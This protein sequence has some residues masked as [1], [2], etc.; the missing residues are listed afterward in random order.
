MA[1]TKAFRNAIATEDVRDIRIMMKDSLIV[2]PTFAEFGERESLARN[3]GQLYDPHDGR[4]FELDKSAWDDD[5]MNKLMVQVV[6]NF[7][8]ERIN[9]LKD[10]VTHLYPVAARSQKTVPSSGYTRQEASGSSTQ[11]TSRLNY[12][13]QRWQNKRN[14]RII[15][16]R[17]TRIV[18]GAAIGGLVGG[19]AA[20]VAGTSFVIGAIVGAVVASRI[21]AV[22]TNGR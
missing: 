4:E 18:A 7:S 2:D 8:H 15:D 16:N 21:I 17:G 11:K 10:V 6:G 1:I 22:K 19:T 5:Y 14:G 13:E 3:I 9:H 20:T 12:H